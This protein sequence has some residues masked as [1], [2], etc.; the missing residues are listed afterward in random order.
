MGWEVDGRGWRD[1]YERRLVT[2]E[3]AISHVPGGARVWVPPQQR[4][5][6]LLLALVG[7]AGEVGDVELEAILLD[8]YGW[9]L[10]EVAKSIDVKIYQATEFSRPY[11]AAGEADF[12]P[13]WVYLAHKA[14]DEGRQGARGIDVTMFSVT[15]P[16]EQGWCCF[17]NILWDARDCARRAAVVLAE[18]N[19][20]MPRTFGDGWIHVS[21]IDWFVRNDHAPTFFDFP[22]PTEEDR[23]IAD[24]V[25]ELLRDGDT[26][27]TGTGRS[28]TALLRLG[29]FRNFRDLGW[30]TEMTLPGTIDLVQDGIVTCERVAS[31]PGVFVAT[32]F[33]CPEDMA[34]IDQ[35]PRFALKPVSYVHNP[36]VIGSNDDVVALNSALSI[37]LTGQIAAGAIGSRVWSGTGGHLAFALG[38]LFSRGGRYVCVMPST[39]AGGEVSRIAAALPEGQLLTVPR[40]LA[41]IV[42]T[43]YGI[44]NLLNRSQRERA[45]ELIAVAHPDHR[46]DLR[47][48]A[49]RLYGG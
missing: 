25:A 41:D 44:A 15:P 42:V 32:A 46:A 16:N 26:I 39:A 17:G 14:A 7:R 19:D 6:A 9:F 10:P 4:P 27:Q 2:A 29:V 24:H 45:R 20:D 30:F 47:R 31:N 38:A 8:D 36:C 5:E 28:T 49:D 11:V 40:E 12:V 3:Q 34:V 23:R 37:D 1:G 18:V 33:N 35:N 21:E 43:E 22:A 48:A 13:W